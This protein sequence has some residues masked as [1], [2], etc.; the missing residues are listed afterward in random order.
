MSSVHV[1][2][3]PKNANVISSHVIYTLKVNEDKSLSI[4]ARIAPHGNEDSLRHEL[5]SD[6][7]MC[8]PSGIRFVLAIAALCKWITTKA[9]AKS[10]FPKTGKAERDVFVIPLRESMDKWH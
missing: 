8:S 2:L 5:K 7:S 1:S 10:A 4:R 6:C 9:D 3:V